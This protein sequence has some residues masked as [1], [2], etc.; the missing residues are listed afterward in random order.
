MNQLQSDRR[1]FLKLMG[2][3]VASLLA[4]SLWARALQPGNRKPNI[5]ILF[6]DDLGYG[7]L[8]V[9]GHPTI[10]TPNL[11]RMAAEGQKWTNF[12]V[13]ASVCT[14]S[15]AALM[16]GRL[17]I[18][19]GMCSDERRVL[20]PD[21]A[22]GI[23]S[24]EVTLAEA[25]K[26]QGYSTACIGK[27]HLGVQPQ[28]LPTNN[29]FDY[30]FGIPYSNDMN[31]VAKGG[32]EIF[33]R[34][35]V[36]YWNAPLMR[37][38]QVVE[39]P[40][41][42]HTLTKRYTE[43]AIKFIQQHKDGPFFVYLAHNMPHVPLFASEKFQDTSLRG[44]F[45]DVVEEIDW[46][47]GQIMATLRKAGLA[48]NTL[49]V[50]TSDNGPWLPF[51]QMGGSAGLLRGG[52]GTTWEGGMREP[53][54]FWWPGTIQSAT[55]ADLGTTMDI[56][57]T[58]CKLAGAQISTDRIIDGVD[59]RPALFG[60]GPSPRETVFYYRGR[61]LYAARYKQFKAHFITQSAY[62][63]ENPKKQHDP[64]LLFD[65]GKDPGEQWDVA[66]EHPDVIAKI[67]D[68]VQEHKQKLVPGRDRLA[69]RLD[70]EF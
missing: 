61:E 22:E 57:T 45:G 36:E 8:G 7:D 46:G 24:S 67:R 59:L 66:E 41:N 18:R 15:R 14:P 44:L 29:G 31:R 16:T 10:H 37:N 53:A 30:Y 26:S 69:K 52:K 39:R 54:I 65:L 27:W 62:Q 51:M 21:S 4:P 32:R 3:G 11:D 1:K 38:D 60:K 2:V 42:Q 13:G 58:A 20:F 25:L 48:E 6:A 43:E 34:P 56:Y 33:F 35:K 23:P 28:Y 40:A 9:Y 64:P 55:V 5:V 17:P 47:A 19:S 68:I 63:K 49:V 12:Y 70:H 50:F